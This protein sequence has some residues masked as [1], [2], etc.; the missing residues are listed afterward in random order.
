MSF[1]IDNKKIA[2]NTIALYFRTAITMVISFFTA[3]VTLEVLGSNDYGLNNLVGS[4]V[5]LFSFLNGSMGTAVQRFFNIEMGKGNNEELGRIFGVGRYLHLLVALITVFFCEIFAV[6]FLHKLNIP[7][8]RL[9]AAHIV[10]QISILSMALNIINVPSFALLKAHEM[11]SKTAM[12]EIIQAFLRLIVLY[13]LCTIDFD[14]LIIYS[15]LNFAVTLYYVIS[16]HLLA[17]KF[18]ESHHSICRDRQLAKS[19]IHFISLLIITVLAELLRKQGFVILI[20]IF[21]GLAINA[22]YAIAMQVSHMV[23]TFIINIKQPIVPQMMAA[24]GAN[25]LKSMHKLIYMGT[26]ITSLLLLIISIP[27]IFECQFL[28][29]IWL[30]TPPTHAD[31]L[32]I[33]VLI[34]SNIASFTYF[35]YQGVHATGHITKQQTYM[36]V[37]YVLN[38]LFVY[39]SF[40]FGFNFYYALYITIFISILQCAINVIF[41]KMYCH[42]VTNDYFKQ[43][44]IPWLI[45]IAVLIPILLFIKIEIPSSLW[46]FLFIFFLSTLLCSMLGYYMMLNKQEKRGVINII[47]KNIKKRN[48]L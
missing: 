16:I 29:N 8:E 4:I 1:S 14:K 26:K 18:P 25:D 30:K 42:L 13:L 40:K 36:S 20:N 31:S 39:V 27:I 47:S 24:Y 21:F 28:L 35:L 6:F 17:R 9:N 15:L 33:L 46:R 43:C 3:R 10:F 7:A 37:L 32:L 41:S 34:N 11:F 38:V 44:F 45:I 2:K 5:S 22:A 12:I 19:M 23:N 48:G